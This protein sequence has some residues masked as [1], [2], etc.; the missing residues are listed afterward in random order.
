[1]VKHHE[2][3]V[4]MAETEI[5]DGENPDAIKL[6]ET[7]IATQ[8]QEI[9]VMKDLATG[10]RP[11]PNQACGPVSPLTQPFGRSMT[12][13]TCRRCTPKDGHRPNPTSVPHSALSATTQLPWPTQ[14]QKDAAEG[15]ARR[16]QARPLFCPTRWV[17]FYAGW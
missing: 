3:A 7:I 2:G 12:A 13:L 17:G 1:M 4:E 8:Q 6:A 5:A 11:G 10:L 14:L 16:R 9:T 15:R